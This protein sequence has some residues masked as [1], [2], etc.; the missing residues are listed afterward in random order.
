MAQHHQ[1]VK[2][3]IDKRH[4]FHHLLLMAHIRV[5]RSGNKLVASIVYL[6]EATDHHFIAASKKKFGRQN[7]SKLM[8]EVLSAHAIQSNSS[9]SQV[10]QRLASGSSSVSN[11]K[12]VA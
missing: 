5:S 4:T 1:N 11:F 8:S 3:F 12:A 10:I 2:Q 9:Q 7:K 6:D